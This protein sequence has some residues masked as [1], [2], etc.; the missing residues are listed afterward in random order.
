MAI[1]LQTGELEFAIKLSDGSV[2][3]WQV[4]LVELKLLTEQIEQAA[5]LPQHD[6]MLIPTARFLRDLAKAYHDAGCPV[7]NVTVAKTIWNIVNTKFNA[8]FVDVQEQITKLF[9]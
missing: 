3:D 7:E 1:E 8:Y 4:D 5:E 2:V 9:E 6:G